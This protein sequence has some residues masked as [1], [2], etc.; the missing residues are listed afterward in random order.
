[1]TVGMWWQK[2]Q[3]NVWLIT[4]QTCYVGIP[5]TNALG[6]NMGVPY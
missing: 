5:L 6:E 4:A 1:M 3:E 2:A